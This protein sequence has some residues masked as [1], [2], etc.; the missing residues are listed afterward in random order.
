[1]W[2]Q[3][4][5]ADPPIVLHI[6]R[7]LWKTFKPNYQAWISKTHVHGACP[8]RGGDGCVHFGADGFHGAWFFFV[9]V[10]V[11]TLGEEGDGGL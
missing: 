3:S 6:D 1:M 9:C 5:Y 11:V 2:S 10:T 8:A 7:E 4:I